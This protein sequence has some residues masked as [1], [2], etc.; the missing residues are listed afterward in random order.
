MKNIK[1]SKMLSKK[2]LSLIIVGIIL[3]TGTGYM[4]YK[5]Y[6]SKKAESEFQTRERTYTATKGNIIAGVKGAG[7]LKLETVKHNF[8]ESVII[9]EIFVAEGQVVKSGDKLVSISEKYL[10]DKL[11]EA[12]KALSDAK[13]AME[14]AKN[15]NNENI[16]GSS[17]NNTDIKTL[18]AA[19][20]SAQENVNKINKLKKS[21]VLYAKVDGM[22][23]KINNTDGTPTNA[24]GSIVDIGDPSK[25][26][27]EIAVSQNDII[28][29]E[30]GQEVKLQIP[31][32]QDESFTGKVKALN[33]KPNTQANSTTYSAIVELNATDHK[34][35]EGMT[36]TAQFIIK[37][38]KDVVMLPN[39]SIS[40]KDGKQFV[41]LK[42]E[43][44][45][46]TEVNIKT[47]F[48]DG[49]NTEIVEGLNEG[50]TVVV[51]G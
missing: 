41:K 48:S 14:Q 51:G 1:K 25:V 29:V 39:K 47:G 31:T 50:D 23:S 26:T 49:K 37:E 18:N 6:K 30:E 43:D 17:T 42:N 35:L 34:L 12:N 22:V 44:G 3:A 5:T 21:S 33:L 9:G 24:S 46:T 10:K 8:D 20:S 15:A 38:V 7:T 32:Y 13:S 4:S 16:N 11:D 45:S 2:T 28:N 19:I 36:T 27:A 40:L